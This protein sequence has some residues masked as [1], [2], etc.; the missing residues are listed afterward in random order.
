[1]NE[2]LNCPVE[3]G[4]K[5]NVRLRSSMKGIQNKWNNAVKMWDN[6]ERSRGMNNHRGKLAVLF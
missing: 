6:P 5:E 1:M 4:R 3:I 2:Y